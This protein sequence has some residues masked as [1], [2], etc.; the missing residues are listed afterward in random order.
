M[1]QSFSLCKEIQLNVHY[2]SDSFEGLQKYLADTSDNIYGFL[3]CL[4]QQRGATQGAGSLNPQLMT[5]DVD[6]R[7][8]NMNFRL[9]LPRAAAKPLSPSRQTE[10]ERGGSVKKKQVNSSSWDPFPAKKKETGGIWL[11]DWPTGQLALG[12]NRL[13]LGHIRSRLDVVGLAR[14]GA[15]QAERRLRK[16]HR[17]SA[18]TVCRPFVWLDF[19]FDLD[20]LHRNRNINYPIYNI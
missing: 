4:T 17:P 3:H 20:A 7:I 5:Q 10:R 11:Q 9:R 2:N 18:G 16:R 14:L 1:L 12:P 15:G 6:K 8:I 13:R 19:K